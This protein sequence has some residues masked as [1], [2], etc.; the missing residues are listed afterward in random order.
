MW[1]IWQENVCLKSLYLGWNGFSDEGAKM[2][3]EALKS[4]PLVNLDISY[5]RIGSDGFLAL[6]KTLA[7]N[8]DLRELKLSGNT[9]GEAAALAGMEQ[10][11]QLD[12][13]HLNE[14]E[15]VVS[16]HAKHIEAFCPMFLNFVKRI[17]RRLNFYMYICAVRVPMHYT[18]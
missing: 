18:H 6:V 2:L 8:D 16:V 17:D 5:N 15:M 4:C 10:L 7:Q 13:L 9:I 1:L 12:E 14:L 11:Q 3:A